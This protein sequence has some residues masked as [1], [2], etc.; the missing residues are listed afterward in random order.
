MTRA[1]RQAAWRPLLRSPVDQIEGAA[2]AFLGVDFRR[3]ESR[4]GQSPWNGHLVVGLLGAER[5]AR[6]GKS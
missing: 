3:V 6:D 5:R 2:G 4:G 1:G